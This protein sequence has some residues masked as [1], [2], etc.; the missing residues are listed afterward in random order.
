MR[1]S[2]QRGIDQLSA[3]IKGVNLN[4]LWQDIFIEILDRLFNFFEHLRRILVPQQLDH[5][6]NAILAIEPIIEIAHDPL[7]FEVAIFQLPKILD[8]NRSSV[9][10]L[11]HDIAHIL[12]IPNQAHA[13]HHIAQIATDQRTSSRIGVILLDRFG[14][15]SQRQGVFGQFVRI[16]F[17]LE[18]RSDSAKIRHVGNSVD[19]P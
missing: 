8:I 12:Q 18:L 14:N 11:D 7:A 15:L 5:A 4:P 16:D 9:Y 13:T 17:N 3:I 2:I 10:R 19:L 1:N 6:L